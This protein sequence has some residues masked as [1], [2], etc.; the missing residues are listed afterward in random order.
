MSK[1]FV[2]SAAAGALLLG[3]GAVAFAATGE[4]NN[5]C[6]EGLAQHKVVNTDCSINGQLH[7][8]TYCFGSADAKSEF[9]KA[10]EDN[11]KKAESFY[12]TKS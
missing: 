3:L 9:M 8:R 12:K 1:A 11:L 6:A 5:M 10:P 2:T 7:G 4:F